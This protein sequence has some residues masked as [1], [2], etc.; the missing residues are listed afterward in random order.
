MSVARWLSLTM[1]LGL[2]ACGAERDTA[3]LEVARR[4]FRLRVT[5]EGQ[6][7]AARVTKLGVPDEVDAVVRLVW[8][9]PEGAVEKGELVARF[10]AT[11]FED[12]LVEG[13]RDLERAGLKVRKTESQIDAVAVKHDTAFKIADLELDQAQRFQKTDEGLYARRE[14]VEDEIDETLAGDRKRIAAALRDTQ[15]SLGQTELELLSIER[16]KAGLKIDKATTGLDALELRAPHDGLM[17]W[18][19]GWRGEPP[20]IGDQMWSGQGVAEF[21]DLSRMEAEVFV[22]EADAG[23]LEVGKS[24]EVMLEARPGSALTATIEKVG[25]VAQPRFRGSPVQYFA[26]TLA[27]EN[28]AELPPRPGQRVQATLLL[29]SLEDVLVVP[30]QAIFVVDEDSFVYVREGGGFARRRVELGARSLGLVVVTSGLD[31]GEVVA[32]G[33]PA[34]HDDSNEV[35]S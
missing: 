16:R 35:D 3:T 15:S 24:A 10:D 29:E 14:I 4:D 18:A 25:A 8:L 30:R 2:C 12:L 11:E 23:G 1:S 22:L 34:G 21:P 17:T 20:E 27:F 31:E 33:R 9:R 5:A 6:L 26:V 19:R 13:Q 28:Q 7:K 32:L